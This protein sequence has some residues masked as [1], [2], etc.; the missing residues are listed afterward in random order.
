MQLFTVYDLSAH[1]AIVIDP[2]DEVPRILEVLQ[3]RDLK[4]PPSCTHMPTLST[5]VVPLSCA[6]IRTLTYLH[7]DDQML[8]NLLPSAMLRLPL[9][10]WADR[11]NAL[12][13]TS[14]RVSN[15]SLALHTPGHSPGSVCFTVPGQ[16]LASLVILYFEIA[17][18]ELIS[19]VRFRCY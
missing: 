9:P 8:H 7:P 13:W 16:D 10:K 11:R 14:G 3:E 1:E 6:S 19:G 2:G 15:S 17:S 18:A 4:S 12:R 5:S